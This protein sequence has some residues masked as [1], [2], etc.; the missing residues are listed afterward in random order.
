MLTSPN[1]V[2]YA[3]ITPVR[4]E[5]K[6]IEAMIESILAQTIVPAKWIIVDDGSTD[7]TVDIVNRYAQRFDF[8]ELIRL[9][10][11]E[12]RMPGG[13]G[14]IPIAFRRL[15]LADF[16]FVGRFDAD[17]VFSSDYINALLAEFDRDLTLGIA[18]GGLYNDV[19]GALIL[20][21]DPEF[22][23]RGALKMYRRQCFQ[24]IGG[25]TTEIG[26][27]TI[28]EVYAWSKGWN[29]RSFYQY[30]VL[31][32][33]STGEALHPAKIYRERGRAEF[34]TW[35]LPCFV[36]AKTFKI[37]L[38]NRSVVKPASYIAGFIHCY[39][40]REQRIQ[41]SSFIQARRRQQWQRIARYLALDWKNE[42]G[43]Y[44]G[45]CNARRK[46]QFNGQHH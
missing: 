44:L 27:D 36:L 45:Q 6:Y 13:E 1:R 46:H 23:V 43:I 3:L 41:E 4:D 37:L 2:R 21:K 24:D 40:N 16:D 33:R 5:E 34:L 14:A 28:D 30:K 17:L 39:F 22:H 25:L 32:R 15:D 7:Q 38:T 26:W 20:E 9:P 29:T 35:S 31:H 12:R 19:N 11:R 10:A 42:E 18:G 8:I